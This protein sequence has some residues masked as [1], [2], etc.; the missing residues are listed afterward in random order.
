MG[1]KGPEMTNE[2]PCQ[3]PCEKIIEIGE[4]VAS[5]KPQIQALNDDM[6]NHGQRGV[7]TRV[8]TFEVKFDGFVDSYNER[9]NLRDKASA[10][11]RFIITTIIAIGM[12]L[13]AALQANKQIQHGLIKLPKI[14][15]SVPHEPPFTAAIKAHQTAAE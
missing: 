8:N 1:T 9:E 2:F 5:M 13:L 15:I 4:D 14:G 11:W 12:L 6:Y 7:K 10:R 3:I